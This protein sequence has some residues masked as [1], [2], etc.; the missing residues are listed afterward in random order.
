MLKNMNFRISSF[1]ETAALHKMEESY[2]SVKNG[3]TKNNRRIAHKIDAR[4]KIIR[5]SHT[6]N[7][8]DLFFC[9]HNV[10]YCK[11]VNKHYK[12]YLAYKVVIMPLIAKENK[13]AHSS[14]MPMF[15]VL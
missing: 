7:S 10:V 12:L 5:L 2:L 4:N 14:D 8:F 15:F 9:C 3:D 11:K 6:I 13:T 1:L